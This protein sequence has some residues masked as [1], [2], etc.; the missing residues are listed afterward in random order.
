VLSVNLSS[1]SLMAETHQPSSRWLSKNDDGNTRSG[2]TSS[3]VEKHINSETKRLNSSPRTV[4]YEIETE[5]HSTEDDT[6]SFGGSTTTESPPL[7]TNFNG[8]SKTKKQTST[9]KLISSIF[10]SPMRKINR[11]VSNKQKQQSLL[12]CFTYEEIANATNNFHPGKLPLSIC[13]VCAS[14]LIQW[15]INQIN[16]EVLCLFFFSFFEY[17]QTI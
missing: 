14:F 6:F 16:S 11:S 2:R 9:C 5:S 10:A 13:G 12:K 3:S 15:L 4:L 17:H 1:H 7:A 8:Q